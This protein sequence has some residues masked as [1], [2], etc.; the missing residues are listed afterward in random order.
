MLFGLL[1]DSAAITHFSLLTYGGK[2]AK[3]KLKIIVN[4]L[5][6]QK[7]KLKKEEKNVGWTIPCSMQPGVATFV[8]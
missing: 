2:H 5:L 6:P 7:K 8:K 4:F 3:N 1:L